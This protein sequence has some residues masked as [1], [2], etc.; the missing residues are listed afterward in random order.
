MTTKQL[1]QIR[2]GATRHPAAAAA[3]VTVH[4]T[5]GDSHSYAN[6]YDACAAILDVPVHRLRNVV[7]GALYSTDDGYA[8]GL[9]QRH[10]LL[11]A[12]VEQLLAILDALGARKAEVDAARLA[13]LAGTE[14]ARRAMKRASGRYARLANRIERLAAELE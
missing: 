6:I 9:C 4:Y 1:T 7:Q 2:N 3:A 5:D 13:G 10:N 11:L 14:Q 12:P 8:A